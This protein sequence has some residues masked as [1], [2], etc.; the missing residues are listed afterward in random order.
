[1]SGGYNHQRMQEAS[2]LDIHHKCDGRGGKLPVTVPHMA[3]IDLIRHTLT[4]YMQPPNQPTVR[5]QPSA[6]LTS[7]I[8]NSN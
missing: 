8:V 7:P 1:M 6:E 4:C 2:W 5:F 3:L